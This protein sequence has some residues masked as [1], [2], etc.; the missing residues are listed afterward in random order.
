M[1]LLKRLE[2][3]LKS[4]DQKDL[5]IEEYESHFSYQEKTSNLNISFNRVAFIFFIFLIISI[6][7]STK[8]VYLGSLE[9]KITQNKLI[10]SEFRS[11]IVDNNGNII[12]KTVITNNVGINPNLVIDKKKLLLNL[13]LIF[14][15][16]SKTEFINIKRKLNKNKFFYIAK[17]IDQDQLDE[18]ILLGDKSIITE[19]KISRIYPHENLFSHIIGQIDDNNNGISGIEK[20]FDKELKKNN[21][22]LKLTVDTDIQYLI[23][24]ELKKSGEI[25]RNLGSAAILMNI[26]SGD[27]ISLVSLPDFNLNKR[28][29]ISD[30]NF[31]NR[32]TKGVYEFGSVFKTFTLAAAFDEKIIEPQTEFADLPKSLTCAGFPIREY[33]NKIPSNLTAEQILIRSGNIGSVRIGQKVG[34]E[35]FK[36]F[37][38]KI[39][40]LDEI[41]FDIEEVGKPIKFNWGKC[42]LAT[43]SFGHGITTTLLQLAKAYAIIT[44][45]GYE[46]NPTTIV[47][48]RNLNE[49]KK[50]L[51]DEVS[52]KILPILRKIVTTKEGTASLANVNGYEIGG[53]TGTAQKSITGSYS[54]KKLNTFVSVFPTSKPKFVLALM[55]DEP[56]I[57]KDYIYHYRDG[58]NIKYKGTPFNT[59]G[60]TTVEVTGQI[61]ENIG[62]ILATKY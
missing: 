9:K 38:S 50:I 61:I 1:K 7:F 57:N 4:N 34:E 22:P 26:N 60:W 19:Q 39:G 30:I 29:E 48:T 8:A 41:D 46:I 21:L 6:I 36:L 62:P 55:L 32:A 49:K 43:A 28:E 12:A 3:K 18:L 2:K 17:K 40:V 31:I 16:K 47:K 53:K 56:K 24:E 51:S 59:A 58:S 14:P 25:F 35:K 42:P 54:K 23:R 5:L 11:G 20:S 37:L 33:D 10:K 44:N 13:Q 52:K 45:G 15:K 27:I